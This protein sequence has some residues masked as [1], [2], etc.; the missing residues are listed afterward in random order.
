MLPGT[1][2]GERDGAGAHHRQP[3][4]VLNAELAALDMELEAEELRARL[5]PPPPAAP[6]PGPGASFRAL[7]HAHAPHGAAAVSPFATYAPGLAS[8]QPPP[9]PFTP[10]AAGAPWPI[11]TTR[12]GT[13]ASFAPGMSA[14]LARA[15]KAI[16]DATAVAQAFTQSLSPSTTMRY[17]PPPPDAMAAAGWP[18]AAAMPPATPHGMAVGMA[19]STAGGTPPSAGLPPS[20]SAH[21]A[22]LAGTPPP[23]PL[24][25]VFY[26]PG[27]YA[28]PP[29]PS[30]AAAAAAYYGYPPPPPA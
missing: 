6:T 29:P 19:M 4:A 30:A 27:A 5:P 25:P 16:A 17:G 11:P 7:P 28:P 22:W 20:M 23:P 12:S 15:D 26:M 1:P 18:Y 24:P 9:P 3:R 14:V 13:P 21:P 2:A 10:A 8:P